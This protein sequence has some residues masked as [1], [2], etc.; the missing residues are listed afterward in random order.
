MCRDRR[1]DE[2]SLEE[3]ILADLAGGDFALDSNRLKR[4]GERIFR[5]M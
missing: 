5:R 1:C 4:N 3:V 2:G